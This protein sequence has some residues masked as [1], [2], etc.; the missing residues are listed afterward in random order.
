MKALVLV[1]CLSRL[2]LSEAL[3]FL[4]KGG[5]RVRCPYCGTLHVTVSEKF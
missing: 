2:C 5:G 1:R 4:P 3:V